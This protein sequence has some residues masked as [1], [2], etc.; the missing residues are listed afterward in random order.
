MACRGLA[1]DVEFMRRVGFEKTCIDGIAV[2]GRIVRCRQ[3]RSSQCVVGKKPA[4][5][6]VTV[7]HIRIDDARYAFHQAFHRLF[8]RQASL[9]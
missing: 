1:D 7:N 2:D 6:G 3:V 9:I 8:R 4:G 5:G